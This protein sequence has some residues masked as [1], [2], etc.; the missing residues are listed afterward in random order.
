MAKESVIDTNVL[1][2]A[3]KPITARPRKGS[4]F[5]K[6]IELLEDIKKGKWTVL[7]SNRLLAEYAQ[8]VNSPN[9][10][11]I[12]TFFKLLLDRGIANWANWPRGAMEKARKCRYPKHDDHVLRTAIRPGSSTIIT[13]EERLIRT[14]A[15]IYRNFGVHILHTKGI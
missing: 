12:V 10:D 9:N 14:D 15:C 3:N 6:R 4:L 1:V 2:N 5:A 7:Y 11:F 8:H 13:E